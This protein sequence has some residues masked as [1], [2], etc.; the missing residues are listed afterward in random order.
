VFP[1]CPSVVGCCGALMGDSSGDIV[2]DKAEVSLNIISG[3]GWAICQEGRIGKRSL[4]ACKNSVL[5]KSKEREQKSASVLV[6]PGTEK[7]R[8]ATDCC[9]VTWASHR[10]V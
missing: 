8:K 3:V 10:R 2:E 7:E 9:R 4:M 6:L 1:D 5:D